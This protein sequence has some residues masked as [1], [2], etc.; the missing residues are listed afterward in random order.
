ML[1]NKAGK[2]ETCFC[3]DSC[4]LPGRFLKYAP[5]WFFSSPHHRGCNCFCTQ[6]VPH[7]HK[8]IPEKSNL[9]RSSLVWSYLRFREY[10]P[11][12]KVVCN[13]EEATP[14]NALHEI[15]GNF[16]DRERTDVHRSWT[17][18]FLSHSRQAWYSRQGRIG[19]P[20]S[21]WKSVEVT[22]INDAFVTLMIEF[23]HWRWDSSVAST[24][25]PN[26]HWWPIPVKTTY[27]YFSTC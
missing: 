25:T 5:S 27:L 7:I 2:N 23:V 11:W 3:Y 20:Y 18:Y 4:D 6:A 22:S 24:R 16:I 14:F 26:S 17:S 13:P 8:K 10:P 9:R 15:I 21:V 12:S 1:A 19:I